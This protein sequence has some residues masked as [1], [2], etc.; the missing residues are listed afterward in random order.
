MTGVQTCALPIFSYWPRDFD[1][2]LAALAAL[3]NL[4]SQLIGRFCGGAQ[5]LTRQRFGDGLLTRYKAEL[6]IPPE[7]EAE[8]A[9][10][11]T[12]ANLYV[13]QR[14]GAVPIYQEQQATLVSLVNCLLAR[15]GRD[16][17][18][19]LAPAWA[20]ADTDE[21]RLRVVIDQVASLTDQS[22]V[23]WN[24]RLSD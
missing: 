8:V 13:M 12:L 1:G 18:A 11:K 16:L 5:Q 15:D 20:S 6:H 4:T 2:S 21:Q 17:E 14:A 23:E 24:R 3:K 19:W 9:V 22:A 10:L 7:L